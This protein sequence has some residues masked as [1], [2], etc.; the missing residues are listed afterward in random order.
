MSDTE[1][2]SA[3]LEALRARWEADRGSRVFLQLADEYRR[4]GRSADAASV[5]EEGLRAN[6]THPAA[7]VLLGRCRLDLGQTAEAIA[8]LERVIE[9]DPTQMVAYRLLVEGY[10]R[11]GKADLARQRL[12]VYSLLNDSDPEIADLRRRIGEID[13]QGGQGAESS[14]P[15]AEPPEEPPGMSEPP[16]PPPRDAAPSAS[17]PSP[18]PSS[19]EGEPFPTLTTDE[20]ERRRYLSAL[21]AEGLFGVPEPKEPEP[22]EPASEAT[23]PLD[24]FELQAPTAAPPADL[25][26]LLEAEAAAEPPPAASEVAEVPAVPAVPEVPEVPEAVEVEP[27]TA[28]ETGAEPAELPA[29]EA[30]PPAIPEARPDRGEGPGRATVTLGRLY[31]RQ[32]HLEE[33]EEIFRQVLEADPDNAEAR[34]G[35]EELAARERPDLRAQELLSGFPGEPSREGLT[36]R[37]RYVLERYLERLRER[38]PGDVH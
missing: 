17:P 32:G 13:R 21:G 22:E 7:R 23:P 25:S 2:T 15:P 18:L 5:L 30:A 14:S 16:Q 24:V 8:E 36:S 38:G 26:S 34:Q 28:A 37:K 35:L 12:R 20:D 6:P 29:A 31:L 11:E 10:L 9:S 27:E 33:A 4:L 3:R 19:A 1:P